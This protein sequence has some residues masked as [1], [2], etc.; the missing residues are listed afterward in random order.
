LLDLEHGDRIRMLKEV[1]T[2]ND[3]AWQGLTGV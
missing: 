2:L 1:A 3:R